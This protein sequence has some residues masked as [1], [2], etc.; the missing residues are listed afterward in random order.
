MALI[1][2]GYG[3]SPISLLY[4]QTASILFEIYSRIKY[5][6]VQCGTGLLEAENIGH[7]EK[8]RLKNMIKLC[9]KYNF[10]SKEHNGD[11]ISI[12]LMREKFEL[13]LNCK[14]FEVDKYICWGTPNDLKTFEY[15]Q[16]CFHKWS[17]HPYC[18]E[19]DKNI[20]EYSG[21]A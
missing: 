17:S 8:E 1:L 11:W 16:S 12:D 10:I 6:V 7:Y 14:L 13:G 2:R 4:T 19:L 9:K 18:L 15:W 20:E 5:F 21:C 3:C